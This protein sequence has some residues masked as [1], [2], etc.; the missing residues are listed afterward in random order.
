MELILGCLVIR[1]DGPVMNTISFEP[2]QLLGG[3]GGD[4]AD[5]PL[6]C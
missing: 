1:C 2:S 6:G 3:G 4:V 5:L